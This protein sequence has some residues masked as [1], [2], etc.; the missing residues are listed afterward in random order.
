MVNLGQGDMTASKFEYFPVDFPVS[1][2]ISGD[3]AVSDCLHRHSFHAEIVSNLGI[4]SLF[5]LRPPP[6]NAKGPPHLGGPFALGAK[7]EDLV[8]TLRFD[9]TRPQAR[10]GRGAQ[11]RSPK[12][13]SSPWAV[14]IN[15]SLFAKQSAGW[16]ISTEM[17]CGNPA[18]PAIKRASCFL[19]FADS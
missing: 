17:T 14:L 4:R 3:R 18:K 7:R 12:G 15:P 9:K 5:R 16:R 10:F 19:G 6:S 2:K 1:G 13:Q 8:Q 11:R